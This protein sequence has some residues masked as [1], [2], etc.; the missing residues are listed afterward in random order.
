MRVNPLEVRWQRT[1][2]DRP[3][4]EPVAGPHCDLWVG[5]SQ[6]GAGGRTLA[7]PS[8]EGAVYGAAVQN[9][10]VY[11]SLSP[12]GLQAL[13]ATGQ[14]LWRRPL[15]LR[16]N[17]VGKPAVGPDGNV[18][19]GALSWF[20]SFTPDGELRFE[21]TVGHATEERRV[22]Q[23]PVFLA[24]GCVVYQDSHDNLQALSPDGE[25][26]WSARMPP[27][28]EGPLALNG[29]G[30]ILVGTRQA[31]VA[32]DPTTHQPAW[33]ADYPVCMGTGAAPAADGSCWISGWDKHV[34][35]LDR[36]GKKLARVELEATP[37][38]T[39][40]LTGDGRV[41]VNLDDGRMA[42]LSQRGQLIGYQ[43]QAR[44]KSVRWDEAVRPVEAEGLLLCTSRYGTLTALELDRPPLPPEPGQAS[45]VTETARA[46]Q[47]GGVRLK[48]R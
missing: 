25:P 22:T 48:R 10:R 32:L 40:T 2:L 12:N 36:Q 29:R 16:R 15:G 35:H 11:L 8:L 26:L 21:R 6:L 46:V 5:S 42:V 24:D 45:S 1:D 9:D 28:T 38:T 19:L 33:Q 27:T 4:A 37:I 47:V 43:G 30:Q 44:Q 41:V 7:H 34:T 39:P 31:L 13:D 14:P 3:L 18:Y 23:A 17:G 20:G